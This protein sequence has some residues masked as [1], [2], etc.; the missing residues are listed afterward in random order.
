MTTAL[1]VGVGGALIAVM[2]IM[3]LSSKELLSSSKLNS[4]KL[5]KALNLA[6]FPLLAVFVLDV[7]YMVGM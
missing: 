6:I 4:P 3:L 5:K 1:G 7:A 2:L